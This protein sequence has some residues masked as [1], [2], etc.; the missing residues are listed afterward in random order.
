MI[1]ARKTWPQF[2]DRYWYIDWAFGTIGVESDYY[3][4]SSIDDDRLNIG[5]CYR[6]KLEAEQ[7]KDRVLAALKPV[8]AHE[9]FPKL[10]VAIFDRPDCP[11][12]CDA[13]VVSSCGIAYWIEGDFETAH[14]EI[15]GQFDASDWRNSLLK[16][17]AKQPDGLPRGILEVVEE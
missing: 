3:D 7:A 15:P 14:Q 16:R 13:A 17:P 2:S 6:T 11:D 9:T 5:N 10:T 4:G 1:M 8:P 12:W